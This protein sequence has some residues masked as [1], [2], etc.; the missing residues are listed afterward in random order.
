MDI[1]L[2]LGLVLSAFF[3]GYTGSQIVGGWLANKYGGKYPFGFGI[4]ATS[5]LTLLT[6]V[7][8]AKSIYLLVAIRFLEGIVGVT[9][10]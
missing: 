6:P 10:I 4:L 3:Y 8:A 5:I 7:A 9:F 1:T 2:H